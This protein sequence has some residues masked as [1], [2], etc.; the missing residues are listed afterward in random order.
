MKRTDRPAV[1]EP[2]SYHRSIK[3]WPKE[4]RPRERLLRSGPRVLSDAELLA[5][6]LRTGRRGLT[7][8]AL[9]RQMLSEGRTL[10]ELAAMTPDA[11]RSLGIGESRSAVLAAA[12]ELVRR[13]ESETEDQPIIHGPEDVAR[14]FGPVLRDRPQEEFWVL[15]LSSANRLQ[16][17][18]Q[19]TVGT[20]NASLVHPRECF[21]PAIERSAAAVIFVHNHPSGNPE[22]SAEDVA[23]TRQLTEAGR[24]LGIPVH[25]HVVIAGTAYTSLAERGEI[26]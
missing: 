3:L 25:D 18:A 6:L 12:F 22:P 9:G 8:V 5:L 15:P 24:L 13:I 4:D 14:V 26:R 23:V 20:L 19:V 7:A 10:R 11:L 16:R 2:A 1:A 21:R 17:P